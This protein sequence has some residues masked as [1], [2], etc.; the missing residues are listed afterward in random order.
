MLLIC[1]IA[2]AATVVSGLLVLVLIIMLIM[3]IV[4][5]MRKRDE[6]SYILED[7]TAL[8]PDHRHAPAGY[9]KALMADQEF[10]A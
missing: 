9:S 10:Y 3:F 7:P 2:D 8:I 6:G 1:G 4:Y 5:R